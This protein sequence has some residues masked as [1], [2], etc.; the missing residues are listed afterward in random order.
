MA[1]TCKNLARAEDQALLKV[2]FSSLATMQDAAT[3]VDQESCLFREHRHAPATNSFLNFVP[4]DAMVKLRAVRR[5]S[6]G[7]CTSGITRRLQ[8]EHE[9]M[10]SSISMR[11]GIPH[12]GTTRRSVE[13]IAA[14][15][16]LA[17]EAAVT[18]AT[19]AKVTSPQHGL[20]PFAVAAANEA[21]SPEQT[22]I[23]MKKGE[24]AG[25]TWQQEV[26]EAA[27]MSWHSEAQMAAIGTLA[28][29]SP[30]CS[31]PAAAALPPTQAGFGNLESATGAYITDLS[32]DVLQTS[33]TTVMIKNLP[34]SLTQKDLMQALDAA[35]YAKQYNFCYVPVAFTSGLCRGYAFINFRHHAAASAIIEHWNGNTQF[36]GAYHWK[37]LSVAVAHMQGVQAL[38]D[39]PSMR[40]VLRIRNPE[41]RPFMASNVWRSLR[42]ALQR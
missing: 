34:E 5:H 14:T 1:P 13:R 4:T 16:T 28:A 19:A 41:F 11:V 22:Q 9:A 23:A 40:K 37:P 39:Q 36:C 7:S 27:E 12:A 35:G 32:E 17:S 6:I 3:C 18:A 31:L 42:R 10:S 21:S 15:C 33:F 26:Q 8:T 24:A 38:L 25:G 30:N 20:G 29:H 2:L